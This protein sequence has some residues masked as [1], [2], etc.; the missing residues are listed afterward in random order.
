MESE[1]IIGAYRY[2]QQCPWSRSNI[3]YTTSLLPQ[4]D[5]VPGTNDRMVQASAREHP[6]IIKNKNTIQLETYDLM[7]HIPFEMRISPN[8]SPLYVYF[9]LLA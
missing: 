9:T 1:T 6:N 4:I 7:D 2:I 5:L 8:Y 3:S